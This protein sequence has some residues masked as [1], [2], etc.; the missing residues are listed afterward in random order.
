MMILAT[1]GA[2]QRFF[3]ARKTKKAGQVLFPGRS[4]LRAIVIF[5]YVVPTV[6]AVII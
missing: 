3:L 6:A 4:I 1:T 2:H 5:P